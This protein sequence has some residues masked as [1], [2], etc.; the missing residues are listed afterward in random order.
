MTW[1]NMNEGRYS[2]SV[3]FNMMIVDIFLY[4]LLGK[5]FILYIIIVNM[6]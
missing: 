6:I 4:T 3:S 5:W 2:F 1:A